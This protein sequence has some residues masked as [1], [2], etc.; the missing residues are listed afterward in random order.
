MR[1]IES[2]KEEEEKKKKKSNNNWCNTNIYN[3]WKHFWSNS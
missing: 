2:K 3:A 1:K